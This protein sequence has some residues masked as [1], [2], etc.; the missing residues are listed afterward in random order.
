M[1][2]SNS[3][4]F[5]A[6]CGFTTERGRRNEL[7]FAGLTLVWAVC[8]TG[9][10]YLI[11]SDL[12][13]AGPIPWVVAAVPSVAAVFVLVEYARFLRQADELQRLIQLQALG[14]GFGGGFFV[15]VGYLQFEK[16]GAPTVSCTDLLAVMPLLYVVGTLMG[17]RRYR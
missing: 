17:W 10:T 14:L 2:Q 16:L 3:E 6:R 1:S 5:W 9:G 12:L 4:S 11:K 13:P 15:I 8:F 7:R